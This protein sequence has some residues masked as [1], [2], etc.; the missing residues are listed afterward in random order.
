MRDGE[1]RDI[2]GEVDDPLARVP[3]SYTGR[4]RRLSVLV[5]D[6]VERADH[7]RMK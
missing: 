7:S 4:F 1:K 6:P 2:S 3:D 5:I